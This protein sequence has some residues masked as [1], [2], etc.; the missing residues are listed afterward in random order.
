MD[1]FHS[2]GS[3][4]SFQTAHRTHLS[5]HTQNSL[6]ALIISTMTSSGPAAFP[7]A[8]FSSAALMSASDRSETSVIIGS[9]NGSIA[10]KVDPH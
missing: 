2:L 6:K 5:Q 9:H 10:Y 7:G 1:F 8:I 3:V 4:F